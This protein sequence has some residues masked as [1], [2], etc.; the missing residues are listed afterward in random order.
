MKMKIAVTMGFVALLVMVVG[1]A[2]SAQSIRANVPFQFVV[3]GKALSAGEYEFVRGTDDL[4]IQIISLKKGPSAAAL[5]VTRLGRGIHTTPGDAHLVF[6]KVGETYFL[7]E[8]WI[9][10][11]DGFLLHATKEHHEH[12]SINIPS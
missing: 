8:L 6:D 1:S 2:Q 5:I 4:S 12:R 9:P 10:E 7:S 3:E 11:M